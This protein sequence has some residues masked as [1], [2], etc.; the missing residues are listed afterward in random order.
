MTL[1]RQ[2]WLVCA[3][4]L[5]SACGKHTSSGGGSGPAIEDLPNMLGPAVCDEITQCVKGT[6]LASLV[7]GAN[8]EAQATASL[9]DKS[10]IELSAANTAGTVKYHGD[11]VDA[12]L[13]GI[14]TISCGVTTQRLKDLP[15]CADVFQGTIAL[16][17][18]CDIDDACTGDAYCKKATT[19]T[20]PGKCT[21]LGAK[22]DTCTTDDECQNHLTCANDGTCQTPGVAGAACG[23][24]GVPDCQLGFICTGANKTKMTAGKCKA[25]ADVFAGK[26]GEVCD[27]SGGK[28]CADGLSCIAMIMGTSASFQCAAKVAAGAACNYG[29]PS[30]C[31][32]GQYC[33]ADIAMGKLTGTCSALPKAGEACLSS[34]FDSSCASGLTCGSD[35]NCRK[36]GRLG[37]ACKDNSDCA[38]DHC[39]AMKCAKPAQCKI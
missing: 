7:G 6:F 37:D 15:G 19:S 18:D 32:S 30:Q 28:L 23:M 2:T 35:G 17:K 24:T 13:A 16:G 8:C 21:A 3:A 10:I 38:S 33:N 1:T 27:L 31:P 9:E 25:Y 34:G 11:K 4:V 5:L 39:D 36:F 22:G 20:C 14:K 12:C 26:A 29:L